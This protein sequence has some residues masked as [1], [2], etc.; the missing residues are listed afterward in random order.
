MYF[1]S[2]ASC[3]TNW[4]SMNHWVTNGL[5]WC[6]VILG[7]KTSCTTNE[8]SLNSRI[9]ST[10][11]QYIVDYLAKSTLLPRTKFISPTG[12]KTGSPQ[13]YW[14]LIKRSS[15]E[16]VPKRDHC[17]L[18]LSSHGMKCLM[19]QLVVGNPTQQKNEKYWKFMNYPKARQRAFEVHTQWILSRCRVYAISSQMAAP[20]RPIL[21]GWVEG[22]WEMALW[23]K[24]PG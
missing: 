16:A 10:S 23:P 15:T 19:S 24:K 17:Q 1:P 7:L 12:N 18:Q 21:A 11:D 8:N 22:M 6:T 14:D 5:L 9:S 2:R 13:S 20:G 4:G 3:I